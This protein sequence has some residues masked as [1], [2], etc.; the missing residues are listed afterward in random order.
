M[1]P[2]LTVQLSDVLWWVLVPKLQINQRIKI[3]VLQRLK[4][5]F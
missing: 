1:L 5:A 3:A 4:P 2:I